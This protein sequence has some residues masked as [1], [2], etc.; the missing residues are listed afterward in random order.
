MSTA[1]E[2][3]V[4]FHNHLQLTEAYQG[5]AFLEERLEVSKGYI[6]KTFSKKSAMGSDLLERIM[7]LF[8]QLNIV[9]LLTGEGD[10]ILEEDDSKYQ[11]KDYRDTIINKMKDDLRDAYAEIGELRMKLKSYEENDAAQKVG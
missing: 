3:F 11:V 4:R 5:R 1:I 8:P 6:T 9:W 7:R 10:M 2:R